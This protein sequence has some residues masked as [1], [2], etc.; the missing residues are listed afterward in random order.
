MCLASAVWCVCTPP[1]CMSSGAESIFFWGGGAQFWVSYPASSAFL[2]AQS[3]FRPAHSHYTARF[4][5]FI[6]AASVH[7]ATNCCDGMKF[8][9]WTEQNRTEEKWRSR[10]Q[11]A[12]R[13][14]EVFVL[15]TA[16]RKITLDPVLES[17]YLPSVSRLA[18]LC[19]YLVSAYFP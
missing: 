12:V 9:I 13:K 6:T 19:L 16:W 1:F 4:L 8:C 15:G 3:Q 5:T 18:C 2:T 11:V 7:C 14:E 10:R 17:S